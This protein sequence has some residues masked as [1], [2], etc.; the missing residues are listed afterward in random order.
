MTFEIP[1]KLHNRD[2]WQCDGYGDR[3]LRG[4]FITCEECD[5]VGHFRVEDGD[6][7]GD[8]CLYV[9]LV[10]HGE[11]AF[12]RYERF[13]HAVARAAAL[14]ALT[15]VRWSVWSNE[16]GKELFAAISA[17]NFKFSEVA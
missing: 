13:E 3:E 1:R 7:D 8:C 17:R 4:E 14:A 15:G 6:C 11:K 2:C 16:Q 5:G 12:E 10:S 9:Y